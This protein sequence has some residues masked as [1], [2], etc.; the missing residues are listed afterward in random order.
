MKEKAH[1]ANQSC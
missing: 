1:K